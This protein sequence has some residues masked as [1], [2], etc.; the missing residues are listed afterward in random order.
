MSL[1]VKMNTKI[2]LELSHFGEQFFHGV[3]KVLTCES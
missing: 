3:K 1:E 2:K